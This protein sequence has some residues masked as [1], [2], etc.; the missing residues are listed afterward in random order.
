MTHKIQAGARECSSAVESMP[1]A[2]EALGSN[3][4]F[5]EKKKKRRGKT[6]GKEGRDSS[7]F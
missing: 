4:S 5:M 2:Y 7:N 1:S 3:A 6:E